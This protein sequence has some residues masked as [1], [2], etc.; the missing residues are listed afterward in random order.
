[1]LPFFAWHVFL[2]LSIINYNV[3]TLFRGGKAL[4]NKIIEAILKAEQETETMCNNAK[5]QSQKIV[6]QAEEDSVK[7]KNNAVESSKKNG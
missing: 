1:M 7:I 3:L 5:T 6:T 4:K 2:Y